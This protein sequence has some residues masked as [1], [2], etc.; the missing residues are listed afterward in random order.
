MERSK[1]K[2]KDK[3]LKNREKTKPTDKPPVAKKDVEQ[4][5]TPSGLEFDDNDTQS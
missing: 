1:S 4:V 2:K 3:I 5:P